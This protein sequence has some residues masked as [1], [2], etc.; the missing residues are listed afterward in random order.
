MYNNSVVIRNRDLFV[1]N[2]LKSTK[3]G[4]RF[5]F[6]LLYRNYI[7]FFTSVEKT[8]VLYLAKLKLML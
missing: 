1:G 2:L 6:I 4:G 7:A 3:V 5:S 8:K